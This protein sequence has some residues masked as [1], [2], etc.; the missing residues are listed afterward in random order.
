MERNQF[1]FYRSIFEAIS[2]IRNDRAR[3]KAYDAICEYALT[4]KEPELTSLPD[5]AAIAFISCKPNLDASRRKAES[6]SRGG[7][8]SESKPD[9]NGKQTESK[10]QA[11]RKQTGSKP[12]AN[13]KQTASEKEREKETE[14][15]VEIENECYLGAEPPAVISWP[16]NDGTEY[17]IPDTMAEEWRGLYPAVDI[18]QELRNMR[19]W[20]IGN[21]ANRKTAR[22]ILRFVTSWL[23]REQDKRH[24]KSLPRNTGYTH[25][26]DRL[27]GMIERGDFD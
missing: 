12:E 7:K 6:G 13:G 26:A 4:G 25:G 10:P 23:A 1:T 21:P 27:A 5:A 17:P 14:K 3:A 2:R 18:D 22:G 15:E 9:A 24:G 16:L 19:G 20:L 8:Q 11:K